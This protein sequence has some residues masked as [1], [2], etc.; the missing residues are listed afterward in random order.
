MAITPATIRM[1]PS[2][3]SVKNGMSTFS[4]KRKIAPRTI[5]TIPMPIPM[6]TL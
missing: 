5:R 6:L 1:M 4:A 3:S 2:V